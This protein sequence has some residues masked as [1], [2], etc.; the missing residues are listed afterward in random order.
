MTMGLQTSNLAFNILLMAVAA[1]YSTQPAASPRSTHGKMR[2]DETQN[3]PVRYVRIS[4]RRQ[5]RK[6]TAKLKAYQ[7]LTAMI[8]PPRRQMRVL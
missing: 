7:K 5:T 4:I 1:S 2:Y 8:N 3:D 6:V